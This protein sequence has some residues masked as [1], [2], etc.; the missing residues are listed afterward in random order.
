VELDT[1]TQKFK[2]W[3]TVPPFFSNSLKP[4]LRGVRVVM[5]D[6]DGKVS[7]SDETYGS[8]QIDGQVYDRPSKGAAS[9]P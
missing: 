8:V 1:A 3:P 9:R 2:L 6:A 4:T 5:F 7:K